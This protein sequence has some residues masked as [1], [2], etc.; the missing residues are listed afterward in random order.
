MGNSNSAAVVDKDKNIME[1]RPATMADPPKNWKYNG[2]HIIQ[3]PV[4]EFTTKPWHNVITCDKCGV[5]HSRDNLNDRRSDEE[6]M[7]TPCSC[8][9]TL[10]YIPFFRS[11]EQ[12]RKLDEAFYSSPCP[13][14]G[15]GQK[16]ALKIKEYPMYG[17][18]FQCPCGSKY[19]ISH[20][21]TSAALI[22]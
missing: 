8:G 21:S 18:Q 11:A 2:S 20:G 12:W 19:I 14:C 3:V 22:E 16:E 7:K 13:S 9:G 4:N 17:N 6:Y 10:Q 1:T 15:R 5:K